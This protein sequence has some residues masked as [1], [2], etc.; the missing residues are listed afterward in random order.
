M[1]GLREPVIPG[2]VILLQIVVGVLAVVDAVGAGVEIVIHRLSGVAHA[3]CAGGFR[4][5]R[6]RGNIVADGNAEL[7]QPLVVQL[8]RRYQTSVSKR[9]DRVKQRVAEDV[10]VG[11]QL[12]FDARHGDEAAQPQIHALRNLRNVNVDVFERRIEAVFA[13]VVQQLAAQVS[14]S[15]R[16][17]IVSAVESGEVVTPVDMI[18]LHRIGQALSVEDELIHLKT[19]GVEIVRLGRVA[20][21]GGAEVQRRLEPS[22]ELGAGEGLVDG[23]HQ[24]IAVRVGLANHGRTAVGPI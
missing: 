13:M 23:S 3:E 16:V 24:R 1:H 14:L 15:G 8:D 5:G 22:I 20:I 4:I 12:G 18:A 17:V 19:I 6:P 9:V 11:R 7:H 21:C 10:V 2:R